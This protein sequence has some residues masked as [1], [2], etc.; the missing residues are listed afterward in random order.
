MAPFVHS[1]LPTTTHVF[2]RVDKVRSS[3]EKSYVGPYKINQET[4][5]IQG[6]QLKDQGINI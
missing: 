4:P 1:D 2:V 3:L 6:L 5:K